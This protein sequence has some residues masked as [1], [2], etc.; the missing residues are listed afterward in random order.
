[1]MCLR[2]AHRWN[3]ILFR[4]HKFVFVADIEKMYR[5]IDV[6]ADDTKYQRLIWEDNSQINTY[7]LQT[8]T[9]GLRPSP[10]LAIKTLQTLAK[11]ERKQYP[12]AYAE[13]TNETYVDDERNIGW[14]E[15]LPS[16]LNSNW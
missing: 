5:C 4:T 8:V 2:Q 10:F 1:M 16:N 14:D 15:T 12:L 7:S 11:L 13:I 9:F 6:H 3:L